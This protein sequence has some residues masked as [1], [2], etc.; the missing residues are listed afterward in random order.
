MRVARI[1]LESN[2]ASCISLCISSF[3]S[4]VFPSGL[5]QPLLSRLKV[6]I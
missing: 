6:L 3:L 5:E 1:G 2:K 4:S